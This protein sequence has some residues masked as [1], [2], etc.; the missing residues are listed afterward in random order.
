MR[1]YLKNKPTEF[2]PDQIWNDGAWGFWRAS[3]R[4]RWV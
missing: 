2:H 4:T 1:I 3:T